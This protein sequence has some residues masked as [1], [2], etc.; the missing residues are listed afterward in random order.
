MKCAMVILN[1]KDSDRAIALAQKCELFTV[2]DKIVIVDNCSGDGSYEKLQKEQTDKIDVIQA[3]KNGG[4]SAGN[5][6]GAK[7]VTEKY[8][9]EYILFANT[10]TIFPEENVIKCITVME[11]NDEIGLL[12]TRMVGPDGK[13]QK[14]SWKFASYKDH[15]WNCFWIHRRKYYLRAKEY[16]PQFDKKLEYV[17]IVRGSFMFFRAE[18]LQKAD[19]FDDNVFLYAEETIIAKRINAV[20]YKVAMITDVSYIHN[21][22]EVVKSNSGYNIQ[23][24]MTDSAYYYQCKYNHIN[25]LQKGLMQI[26]MAIGR[27][28]QRTI[29]LIKKGK[30]V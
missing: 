17:D 16:M 5:N 19:F 27:I 15:L 4:F 25:I 14:A 23:K 1:Y 3:K 21:H 2:I 12:S 11:E 7:Y 18:A 29:D 20:G 9:P 24:R 10:D 8:K 26:C 28:E 22:I 30:K 13:E 6:V